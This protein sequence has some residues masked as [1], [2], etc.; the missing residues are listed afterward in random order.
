MKYATI[1]LLTVCLFGGS[2]LAEAVDFDDCQIRVFFKD[3]AQL[4]ELLGMGLDIPYADETSADIFTTREMAD[5]LNDL[6]FQ[7]EIVHES[8]SAFYESRLSR[9]DMGGY[10]TL[11]ELYTYLDGIIADHPGIITDKISIGQTIEGRDV[12]AVKISDNPDVNEDEPEILLTALIH[13][14]EVATPEVLF[15]FMDYLTDNYGTDPDAQYLVD[16]REI[17]FVVCVNP[18]GYYHN[19]VIA[20]GGG[21]MWRKNRRDNGDG[22]YGVDIN[23]NFSYQ[24]ALDEI[25]SSS[26]TLSDAYRGTAP[27]SEP[28][29][30]I[31]R[32]FT[33]S[34]DFIFTCYYHSY[35]R[36][37]CYPWGY[38][39]D[40]CYGN[41][42]FSMMGDTVN[43]MNSYRTGLVANL[44]YQVNGLTYDWEFG[45][46]SKP[47]IYA[48]TIEVGTRDDGFWP[49]MERLEEIKAENLAPALFLARKAGEIPVLEIP[50]PPVIDG[51][52]S[53]VGGPTFTV[54]WSETDP[55]NPAVAYRLVELKGRHLNQ[56]PDN[57]MTGW[58]SPNFT[59]STT[60]YS[61]AP[62]SLFSAGDIQYPARITSKYPYEVQP[63]DHLT[64]DAYYDINL[65]HDFAYV[66]VSTDGVNYESLSGNLTTDFNPNGGNLGNGIT[67]TMG[68]WVT[69]DFDLADYVGETVFFRI[70]YHAFSKSPGEG[71]YIDNAHPLVSFDTETVLSSTLT[72]PTMSL[73][74]RD[75]GIYYYQVQ[76]LDAEDQWSL[77]SDLARTD[78]LGTG[79]AD[80]DLDG[81]VGSVAD[82]S[83]LHL[84]LG[85]GMSV[86]DVYPDV[87]L[88]EGDIDC[89][90]VTYTSADALTLEQIVLGSEAPCYS[91]MIASP[92]EDRQAAAST[93][94]TVADADPAP[95]AISLSGTDFSP[96][97]SA[98][99]DLMLDQAPAGLL[100]FKFRIRYDNSLLNLR[101]VAPGDALANWQ[102]LD[103][104]EIP[105]S[106]ATDVII[107]GLAW[108]QGD[109]VSSGDVEM[110]PTPISLV[111]LSFTYV[112]PNDGAD[113]ELQFAWVDLDDNS[114]VLGGMDG[115]S[116][117]Q[118]SLGLALG[119]FDSE[120][121]P[122][123]SGDPELLGPDPGVFAGLFGDGPAALVDF[124]NGHLLHDPSCCISP[125][126]DAN[127]DGS[128]EPT[129]GDISIIIDA[130]FVSEDP[131]KLSCL[132]EADVNQ[133]GGSDPTISDITIG[134]ISYLIDYLFIT[135]NSLGLF[136]CP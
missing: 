131:T 129:I 124:T 119:V 123:V 4:S 35:G 66:E 5:E 111:R 94:R 125:V 127:G 74:N 47:P 15:Y 84:Y 73:D 13:A 11:D 8:V 76:V 83:L 3:R 55:D 89:D 78:V 108:A 44:L 106:S 52:A 58:I 56:D 19:Q 126:G 22:S 101:T 28:E 62:S 10:K 116:L 34:H 41:A 77:G 25:G 40:T 57:E 39:T 31:M 67:G 64:F 43:S 9:K 68:E 122:F 16:N 54:S 85:Q 100:A 96:Y 121:L 104:R 82:L 135:G 113:T 48:T 49:T 46:P 14:R 105:G 81:V 134:D 87:Q 103:Y 38:T 88:A 117:V 37:F 90:G 65:F 36:L 86:F 71:I 24:W 20:P 42:I 18:D 26:S 118:D 107:V 27:F 128:P 130:L 91:T 7:V 21:G 30:Q 32:D 114:L 75:R 115:T 60:S 112:E 69:A 93:T 63:G 110:Q 109:P 102:V 92:R 45:D 59:V 12:W 132:E 50:D 1:L 99:V 133:S 53:S 61:T 120:G 2:T 23:R 51:L 136:D 17:W 97:D 6:G 33:L 72:S 70:S 95:Y 80:V 79:T 98:Q 29:T